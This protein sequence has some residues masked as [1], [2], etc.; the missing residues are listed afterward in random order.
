MSESVKTPN[1][2]AD[3]FEGAAQCLRR[4]GRDGANLFWFTVTDEDG[5]EVDYRLS[6]DDA[7]EV[8]RLLRSHV[9]A[10]VAN[11][12][13]DGVDTDRLRD[14]AACAGWGAPDI[15]AAAADIDRLRSI[16][17]PDCCACCIQ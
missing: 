4:S 14:I 11:E 15:L 10:P 16:E 6:A 8:A 2:L 7:E 17:C 13:T 1:E 5:E 3:V 12:A 9:G